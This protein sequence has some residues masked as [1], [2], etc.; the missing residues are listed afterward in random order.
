L[1]LKNKYIFFSPS[2]GWRRISFRFS[3]LYSPLPEIES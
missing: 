2:G 1:L 3:T